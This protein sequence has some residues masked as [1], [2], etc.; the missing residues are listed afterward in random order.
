MLFVGLQTSLSGAKAKLTRLPPTC[1]VKS[2]AKNQFLEDI[3]EQ[4][5]GLCVQELKKRPTPSLIYQTE[6]CKR[7]MLDQTQACDVFKVQIILLLLFF[8]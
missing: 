3:D 8:S 6:S 4:C 5:R 7:K 1:I 2:C